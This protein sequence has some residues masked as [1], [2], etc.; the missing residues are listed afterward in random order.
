MACGNLVWIGDEP[1]VNQYV[2]SLIDN[3]L[4]RHYITIKYLCNVVAVV[5][6]A[7]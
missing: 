6:P 7:G 3:Y 5:F 4:Q 1:C 2:Q